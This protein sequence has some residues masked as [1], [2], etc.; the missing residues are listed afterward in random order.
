MTSSGGDSVH[1]GDNEA[2]EA[3]KTSS[4]QEHHR[5]CSHSVQV[6]METGQRT[7]KIIVIIITMR[8]PVLWGKFRQDKVTKKKE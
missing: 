5:P 4:Q 8:I 3:L 6:L 7:S 2:P 1:Q